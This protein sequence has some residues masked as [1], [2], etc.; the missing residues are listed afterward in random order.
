MAEDQALVREV[1]CSSL[2]DADFTVV[3]AANGQEA[4]NILKSQGREIKLLITD[5]VMPK[6]GGGELLRQ[7]SQLA[8]GVKFLVITGHPG[9]EPVLSANVRTLTKPFTPD[10]LT[11][12]AIEIVGP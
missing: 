10:E 2:R 4:L 3:E 8:Q 7:A 6:V 5:M 9:Y 1:V 11:A 12:A